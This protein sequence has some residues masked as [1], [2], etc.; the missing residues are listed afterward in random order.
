M[1]DIKNSAPPLVSW[2]ASDRGISAR[3]SD[4]SLALEKSVRKGGDDGDSDDDDGEGAASSDHPKT[5]LKERAGPGDG[6]SR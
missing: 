5:G 2:G 4:V 1:A 6:T 3:S